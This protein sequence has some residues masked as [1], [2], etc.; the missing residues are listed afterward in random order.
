MGQYGIDNIVTEHGRNVDM[1]QYENDNVV[2]ERG[3]CG[4][5]TVW[6]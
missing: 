1:G 4:Y 5:G 2:T 6:N 3:E